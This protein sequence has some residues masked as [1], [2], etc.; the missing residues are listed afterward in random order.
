MKKYVVEIVVENGQGE[1]E[2]KRFYFDKTPN[3]NFSVFINK[4]GSTEE[5]IPSSNWLTKD[6]KKLAGKVVP[7]QKVS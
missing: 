7:R 4:M 5:G 1:V 3:I 2:T 6:Q